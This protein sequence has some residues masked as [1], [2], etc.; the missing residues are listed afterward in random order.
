MPRLAKREVIPTKGQDLKTGTDG[1]QMFP[2]SVPKKKGFQLW[3]RPDDGKKTEEESSESKP[4]KESRDGEGEKPKGGKDGDTGVTKVGKGMELTISV[5]SFKV[6]AMGNKVYNPWGATF[7]DIW[8]DT[9]FNFKGRP[10]IPRIHLDYGA[11]SDYYPKNENPSTVCHGRS[12][13]YNKPR[14]EKWLTRRIANFRYDHRPIWR[15]LRKAI[16]DLGKS[17]ECHVKELSDWTSYQL[18]AL[19]RNQRMEYA[20]PKYPLHQLNM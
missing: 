17:E 7:G 9:R 18:C 12:T 16:Y 5:Q 4:E 13:V 10:T 1:M 6:D 14:V 11:P 3:A 2:N 19:R 8:Q 20:V 15:N